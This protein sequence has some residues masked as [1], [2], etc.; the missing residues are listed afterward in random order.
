MKVVLLILGL[1]VVGLGVL[2]FALGV[3]S[4]SGESPG[5]VDGMLS[6]CPQRPNCVCSEFPADGA[7]Y[8]PPLSFSGDGR[9]DPLPLLDSMVREMGGTVLVSRDSYLA[10]TF[11]SAI[12]GF[13]DDLELRVDGDRQRIHVRS[14]SRVGYSDGGVNAERV[15]QLRLRWEQRGPPR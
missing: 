15:E 13:V 7:H 4:R 10:A 6:R 9:A 1:L 14:G 2:F 8:A 11:S 5:L 3:V 12:F